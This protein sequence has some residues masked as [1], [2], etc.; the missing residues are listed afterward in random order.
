[1]NR[2]PVEILTSIFLFGGSLS[3]QFY[4]CLALSW[5]CRRWRF[6]VLHNPRFWSVLLYTEWAKL[7]FFNEI[8]HRSMSHKL[9]VFLGDDFMQ[10]SFNHFH[11]R[12]LNDLSRL[13]T[14]SIHNINH[15]SGMLVGIISAQHGIYLPQLVIYRDFAMVHRVRIMPKLFGKA[16]HCVPPSAISRPPR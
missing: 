7:R 1:M 13:R 11:K 12:I 5:T 6:V 16:C 15:Y 2:L 8:F 14:L 3:K 9:D 10:A 4:P